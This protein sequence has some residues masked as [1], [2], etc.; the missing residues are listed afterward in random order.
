MANNTCSFKDTKFRWSGV[1]AEWKPC[2]GLVREFD[3]KAEALYCLLAYDNGE[4]IEDVYFMEGLPNG[5][6]MIRVETERGC[7]E[8]S[9]RDQSCEESDF[10]LEFFSEDND[11][12]YIINWRSNDTVESYRDMCIYCDKNPSSDFRRVT[13]SKDGRKSPFDICVMNYAFTEAKTYIRLGM[14]E[15]LRK[16]VQVFLGEGKPVEFN[17]VEPQD[18]GQ[19][20]DEEESL[21]F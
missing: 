12:D 10:W 3:S 20:D 18:S 15:E 5:E 11:G 21:P 8:I 14:S 4:Q 6:T 17:P 9:Y 16:E 2:N 13:F 19:E 7:Y 1:S